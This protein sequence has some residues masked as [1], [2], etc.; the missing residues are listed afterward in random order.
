MV[1]EECIARD[2]RAKGYNLCASPPCTQQPERRI[3]L[4]AFGPHKSAYKSAY[5]V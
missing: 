1:C 2:F 5:G 3:I 4:V